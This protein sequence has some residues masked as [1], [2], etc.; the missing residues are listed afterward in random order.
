MIK[1]M[2]YLEGGVKKTAAFRVTDLDGFFRAEIL[3]MTQSKMADLAGTYQSCISRHERG[4]YSP[5]IH[6]QYVDMGVDAWIDDLT[7]GDI[8]FLTKVLNG[9]W[10]AEINKKHPGLVPM[11]IKEEKYYG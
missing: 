2:K 6:A 10:R 9:D 5:T 1:D 11:P 7:Y 4:F 3:R 8:A